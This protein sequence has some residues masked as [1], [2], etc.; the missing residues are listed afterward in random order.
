VLEG[1]D[2]RGSFEFDLFLLILFCYFELFLLFS[3]VCRFSCFLL[4][5]RFFEDSDIRESVVTLL[6]LIEKTDFCNWFVPLVFPLCSCRSECPSWFLLSEL[7]QLSDF[8]CS[9]KGFSFYSRRFTVCAP[10]FSFAAPGSY[11][12]SVDFPSEQETVPRF[13]PWPVF[14]LARREFCQ[15]G[16]P[17]RDS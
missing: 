13:V 5:L 2:F 1:V 6:I 4:A 17:A 9:S 12:L 10:G 7:F 8:S 14:P 3:L 16:F 15:P 11:F